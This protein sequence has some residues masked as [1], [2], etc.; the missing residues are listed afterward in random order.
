[1]YVHTFKQSFV[2]IS[3][4]HQIGSTIGNQLISLEIKI[5]VSVFL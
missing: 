4:A 5:L 3:D 1:M 2:A